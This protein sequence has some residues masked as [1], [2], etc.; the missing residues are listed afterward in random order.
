[1]LNI[2]EYRRIAIVGNNGSGKSFLSEKLSAL[3]GLPLVHLDLEYWRPGWEK[4]GE[5]EWIIKQHEFTAKKSWI[6]EGNYSGTMDLRFKT[7]DL[8]VFLDFSRF[9]CLAGV[10]GRHGKKRPDMPRYLDERLNGEFFRFLKMLWT[11]KKSRRKKII[12]LHEKYPEKTFV[13]IRNRREM[14]MLL[15]HGGTRNIL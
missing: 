7:A 8:I 14:K 2:A 10:F 15:N 6:I 1:M 3:T 5:E 11:F 9:V 12:A 4:P 13:V